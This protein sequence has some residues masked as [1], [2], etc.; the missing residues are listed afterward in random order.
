MFAFE[1]RFEVLRGQHVYVDVLE[2]ETKRAFMIAGFMKPEWRN[3]LLA[4]Y[5]HQVFSETEMNST[6]YPLYQKGFISIF[7]RFL[8][9]ETQ[10]MSLEIMDLKQIKA[11]TRDIKTFLK[12]NK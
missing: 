7:D 10:G 8:L 3:S 11:Y 9:K 6:L 4:N 1:K 12:Q 2:E 5:C